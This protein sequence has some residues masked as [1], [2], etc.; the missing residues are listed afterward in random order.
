MV[1]LTLTFNAPMALLLY[2]TGVAL[3]IYWRELWVALWVGALLLLDVVLSLLWPWRS[4]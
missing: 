1:T 2:L 3:T 4:G